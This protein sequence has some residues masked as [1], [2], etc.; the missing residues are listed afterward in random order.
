MK[1][2]QLALLAWFL[3][4]SPGKT[5]MATELK[6]FF[7]EFIGH[8]IYRQSGD[9]TARDLNVRILDS[10]RGFIAVWA[11]ITHR[12]NGKTKS[13]FTSIDFQPSKRP[14]IY[15]ARRVLESS[16][17]AMKDDFVNGDP[18]IWA[19]LK[20][21]TLTVFVVTVLDS[22]D[23]STQI[24]DRILT[25]KGMKLRFRR[26]QAAKIVKEIEANLIRR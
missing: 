24:Y 1:I 4:I 8:T 9:L 22:G 2:F 13:A 5:L 19:R 6:D 18:L 3:V 7:G 16:G 21:N 12:A 23:F 26:I 15:Q 10:D 17:R 11:T 25:P 20:E 14:G